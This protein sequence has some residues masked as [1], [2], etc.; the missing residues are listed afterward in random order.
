MADDLKDT[1]G[2]RL[3]LSKSRSN[4]SDDP[5]RQ[6]NMQN[7]LVLYNKYQKMLRPYKDKISDLTKFYKQ[8]DLLTPEEIRVAKKAYT[9]MKSDVPI[10]ELADTLEMLFTDEESPLVTGGEVEANTEE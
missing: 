9:L 8:N 10:D 3:R 7:F 4:L 2:Q 5:V 6:K 1:L